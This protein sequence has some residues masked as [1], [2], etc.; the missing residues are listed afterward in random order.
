MK[1]ISLLY[2]CLFLLPFTA[3]K[4]YLNEESYGATTQVFK[5]E[6]GA[7]TLLNSLYDR[8]RLMGYGSGNLGYM[9]ES[10]T[11]IW[12]RGGGN[13]NVQLTE[14]RTLDAQY[15]LNGNMWNHYYKG[16]WNANYFLEQAKNITWSSESK[17]SQKIGEALTLKAYFL[18]FIVN[19]WGGVHLPR[20]TDYNEGLIAARSTEEEF[21]TEIFKCL[22]EALTTVPL[23]STETGRITKPVVE[24]FLARVHLYH[25]DWDKVIEY[26][27]NV[28]TKYN[29]A[30]IPKWKDLWNA[31]LDRSKE[32]I[33]Q[34]NWG[35][36]K[37]FNQ[38]GANFWFQAFSPFID[39]FPGIQTEL[40]WTGYGGVQMVASRFYLGLFNRDADARWKDGFQTVW[41]YNKPTNKLPLQVTPY[42]DTA[43]FFVPYVF[44]A[45]DR[46]RAV[47]RYTAKDVN[48]LYS[49]NGIPKDPKVFIGF[50]KFD[51]HTRPGALSTENSAEDYS[52]IRLADV[53]LMRAEAYIMKSQPGLA[54]NDVNV[55]R[56]RATVPGHEAEMDVDASQMTV[57]FILDERARELGGEMMRWF[58]LKRTGT[59]ITRVRAYN[60]EASAYIQP[61]HV[62]RPVPQ[63]Q[64]DGMPDPST[65]GQ[66]T[67]Y[68]F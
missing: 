12:L 47:N 36:D 56:D 46:A 48:D 40:I 34:V 23:T 10:G 8:L 58:D 4:K 29:Y 63:S 64:F 42:V 60:P 16:V 37:S 66:N 2:A 50:K 67:G 59:L 11:D 52:V 1:K 38:A 9:T 39:Q 5:T 31:A 65:L 62:L 19:T 6:E 14:Y 7:L 22:N 33:W 18:F 21:Y 17:K 51:D 53:Y 13:G 28:I 49:A 54:A 43:L 44:S 45:A 3:C 20:T 27:S 32:F 35:K 61:F 24:A 25:K 30:L 57:D 41:Y 26:S 68:G 55:I 15:G